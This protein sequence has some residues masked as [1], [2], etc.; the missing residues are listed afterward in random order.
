MWRRELLKNKLYSLI[1]IGIGALSV[2]IEYDGTFF[3]F[4]LMLG[5][6]LFF[7]KENWIM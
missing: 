2:L 7:A 1:L 3:I 4:S 5:L 6:P